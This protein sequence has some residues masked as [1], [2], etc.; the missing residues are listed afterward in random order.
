MKPPFT[1][2]LKKYIRWSLFSA[3]AGI[4]AGSAATLFLILLQWATTTREEHPVLIWFL[5]FAGFVIG[6]AYHYYGRDVAGGNNLI[7]DEIHHPKKIVPIRMAPLILSSTVMTHLFGGSAG[8][9]GTAVQMG[10]SLADQLSSFFRI[11]PEERKIL[12]QL[13]DSKKPLKY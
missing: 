12:L 2:I 3:L 4:L 6:L 11:E 10:A 5:P 1:Q 13:R 7:L 9:E 8:R